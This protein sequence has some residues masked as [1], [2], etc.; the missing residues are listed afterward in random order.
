[1]QLKGMQGGI[2]VPDAFFLI[3]AG[4]R[5]AMC[6]CTAAQPRRRRARTKRCWNWSGAARAGW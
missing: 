6:R 1:M 3:P 2:V 4:W 5:P